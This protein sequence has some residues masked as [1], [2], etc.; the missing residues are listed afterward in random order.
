MDGILVS[1]EERLVK[2]D[3]AIYA[4]LLKKF[5]LH[6]P[7]CVFIDDNAANVAAAANLGFDAILFKSPDA[8][9]AELM[10]RGLL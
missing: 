1:G 7:D 2:P 5:N 8:L 9:H 10:R 3:P 6:S 4:R